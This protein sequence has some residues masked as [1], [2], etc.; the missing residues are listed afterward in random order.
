MHVTAGKRG[1]YKTHRRKHITRLE[2]DQRRCPNALREIFNHIRET[3]NA[4]KPASHVSYAENL[5][6]AWDGPRY[7][8]EKITESIFE[9]TEDGN[10]AVEYYH[11]EAYAREIG[12]PSSLILLFS[13]LQA[14]LTQNPSSSTALKVLKS[15]RA[16]IIY[17]ES[18]VDRSGTFDL[19]AAVSVYLGSNLAD[20]D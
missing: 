6:A 8:I 14:D 16:A 5:N 17:C 15:L 12:V 9:A 13:R 1:R 10:H 7:G 3:A 18:E 4:G 19:R 2:G 20:S 11:M